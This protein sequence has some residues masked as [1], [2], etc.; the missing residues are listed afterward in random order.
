[1]VQYEKKCSEV[2]ITHG[3]HSMPL[4]ASILATVDSRYR[5]RFELS[6]VRVRELR[7]NDRSEE[8]TVFTA[9]FYLH[10]VHFNQI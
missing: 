5:K 9:S 7:T 2:E 4:G 3:L 1:M 6:G 10:S 8:K